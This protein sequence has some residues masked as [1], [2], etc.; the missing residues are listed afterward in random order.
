MKL[1]VAIPTHNRSRT[2]ALTLNSLGQLQADPEID[3][4]CLVVDNNSSDATPA[5]VEAFARTAPFAVRWVLET[6]QG[7][8]FARN[9]AVHEA[10]G[11]MIF[12]ID[13]DVIVESDW[14]SQLMAE[15]GRRQLDA[16]CGLVLAQWQAPRPPW[17]DVNLYGK[18]AVHPEQSTPPEKLSQYFSANVGFTRECFSR[19][20]LFREDLGVVGDN[21]MS[22]EDT[23][24][25]ARIIGAGGRIGI[26]PSAVVHHLIGAERMTRP[27]FR[28][29]AF[30]FGVGSAFSGGRSHNRLDKLIK[31]LVRMGAAAASGN[32]TLAFYHQLE[33][34]NFFGYWYGRMK[35][36][37]SPARR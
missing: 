35:L 5:V 17:L 11:A 29:K 31:N 14:A 28:R 1:T 13:D 24:L 2:L 25:F 19:F 21:P 23:E 4:D 8:S 34:V 22:G 15:I 37:R 16:A 6:R 30:A 10:Q 20:G 36:Q 27:Y 26:A 18:L 9:R 3:L 33:C 7:S 12:F 32:Q